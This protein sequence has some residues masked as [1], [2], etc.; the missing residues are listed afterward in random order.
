M[1]WFA[2]RRLSL[3]ETI[4]D[5]IQDSK[6]R[7]FYYIP[8]EQRFASTDDAK[9]YMRKNNYRFRGLRMETKRG[10]NLLFLALNTIIVLEKENKSCK[11][12]S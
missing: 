8:I 9:L 5:E 10:I 2:S 12:I 7:N 4:E 3:L 1:V 6:K 11:K